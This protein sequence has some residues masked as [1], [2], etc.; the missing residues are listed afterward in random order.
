M[1]YIT[2]LLVSVFILLI[3]SAIL[4]IDCWKLNQMIKMQAQFLDDLKIITN[5]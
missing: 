3:T 2:L 1:I 4:F 5:L